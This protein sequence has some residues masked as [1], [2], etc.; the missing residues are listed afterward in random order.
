MGLGIILK[1]DTMEVR[2]TQFVNHRVKNLYNNIVTVAEKAH[3]HNIV[4]L[5]QQLTSTACEHFVY[6]Q[7]TAQ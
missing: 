6:V 1:L 3:P 4:P 2:D 5:P 7:R